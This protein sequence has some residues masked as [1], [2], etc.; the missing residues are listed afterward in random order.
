MLEG[1]DNLQSASL[2]S[3]HPTGHTDQ[4]AGKRRRTPFLGTSSSVHECV[5]TS[6]ER[7]SMEKKQCVSNAKVAKGVLEGKDNLLS[8][9]LPDGHPHWTH[10]PPC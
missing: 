6:E 7:A 8:T 1:K 9:S 4:Q 5:A 3:G 10:R 2:P